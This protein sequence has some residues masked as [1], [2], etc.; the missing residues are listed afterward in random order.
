MNYFSWMG[1]DYYS[2]S[3]Q[4]NQKPKD[5]NSNSALRGYERRLMQ[6]LVREQTPRVIKEIKKLY[7][8]I[9]NQKEKIRKRNDEA[10]RSKQQALTEES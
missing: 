2:G 7:V 10:E 4:G 6:L 3:K 9:E 1:T 5:P 8:K